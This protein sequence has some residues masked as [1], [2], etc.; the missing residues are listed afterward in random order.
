MS[1]EWRVVLI[2]FGCLFAAI[3][4]ALVALGFLVVRLVHSSFAPSPAKMLAT[5]H[6]IATFEVPA[7]YKIKRAFDF[8][9]QQTVVIVPSNGGSFRIQ[10]QGSVIPI[11]DQQQQQGAESG[12]ALAS[13][14]LGCTDS[15]SSAEQLTVKHQVVH[16]SV[17]DCKKGG[18]PI[19]SEFATFAANDP[20]V[21]LTATGLVDEFDDSAVRSL[22]KSIR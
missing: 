8:G 3:A 14:L 18:L 15:A 7:G 13:R 19:R 22:L 1:K 16:I 20:S 12:F 11:S 2:V 21:S 4:I 17:L 10:L 5:A 9:F 6:K